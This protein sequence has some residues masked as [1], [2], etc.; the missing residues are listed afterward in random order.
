MHQGTLATAG[1]VGN[2]PVSQ[3]YH[4]HRSEGE[5]A[6]ASDRRRITGCRAVSKKREPLHSAAA[7]PYCMWLCF[8]WPRSSAMAGLGLK[9]QPT[10]HCGPQIPNGA[11]AAPETWGLVMLRRLLIGLARLDLQIFAVGHSTGVAMQTAQFS[12]THRPTA[13]VVC[14][15]SADC[16]QNTPV[17]IC[18]SR[19]IHQ[20]P[21]TS[22]L[23]QD[24]NALGSE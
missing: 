21:S 5:K 24:I 8:D 16:E 1:D 4:N 20:H 6:V 9:L 2:S 19:V 7:K 10:G 11:I 23:G 15:R 14:R 12:G 17:G 13:P 3:A 18:P 22:F